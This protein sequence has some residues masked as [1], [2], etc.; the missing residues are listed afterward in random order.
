MEILYLHHIDF[1]SRPSQ[2][3]SA[4]YAAPSPK[5]QR[6][7]LAPASHVPVFHVQAMHLSALHVNRGIDY[8]TYLMVMYFRSRRR[9]RGSSSPSLPEKQCGANCDDDGDERATHGYPCD[10]AFAKTRRAGMATGR[11]GACNRS[12]TSGLGRNKGRQ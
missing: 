11:C 3:H 10:G 8:N 2:H 6:G 12:S 1:T 4:R 7:L 5:A 9:F